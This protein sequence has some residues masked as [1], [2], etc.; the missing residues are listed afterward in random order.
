[1]VLSRAVQW[2]LGHRILSYAN[3]TVIFA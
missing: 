3:K 1:M 2:H